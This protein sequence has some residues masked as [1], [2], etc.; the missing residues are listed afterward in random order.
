ML[1]ISVCSEIQ[2]QAMLLLETTCRIELSSKPMHAQ[3]A[4]LKAWAHALRCKMRLENPTQLSTTPSSSAESHAY[5]DDFASASNIIQAP[6]APAPSAAPAQDV[7]EVSSVL[8]SV[9]KLVPDSDRGEALMDASDLLNSMM[10]DEE[11]SIAL[12]SEAEDVPAPAQPHSS[13]TLDF[14]GLE[15]EEG[16]P[17]AS[18][19]GHD[20][21]LAPAPALTAGAPASHEVLLDEDEVDSIQEESIHA[22]SRDS[23]LGLPGSA[24]RTAEDEQVEQASAAPLQKPEAAPGTEAGL[25]PKASEPSVQLPAETSGSGG[26]RSPSWSQ[27]VVP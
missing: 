10:A 13:Y 2:T 23:E 20:P 5:S 6:A 4:N 22:A 16:T 21:S 25:E 24:G 7:L 19:D 9:N 1:R 11:P 27:C 18:T 3:S 12:A 8:A 17:A 15:G 26:L 14:S